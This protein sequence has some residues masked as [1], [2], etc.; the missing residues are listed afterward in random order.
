LLAAEVEAL[1]RPVERAYHLPDV[2]MTSEH[3]FVTRL[4][5]GKA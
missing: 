5:R 3:R 4:E 2:T 1:T